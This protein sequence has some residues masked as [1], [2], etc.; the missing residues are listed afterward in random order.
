MPFD[1]ANTP[2]GQCTLSAAT[3]MTDTISAGPIGPKRPSV[4]ST[5]LAISVTDGRRRKE[6]AGPEAQALEE[7]ARPRQSVT[8]KPAEE[9]LGPV[10]RHQRTNHE[11]HQQQACIHGRHS[12]RRHCHPASIAPSMTNYIK[13]SD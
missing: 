1:W 6:P 8:A 3:T 5:P 4:T 13:G 7:P 10:R 11:P 12:F 2:F 9:L